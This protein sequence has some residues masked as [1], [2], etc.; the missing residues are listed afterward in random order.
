MSAFEL[1]MVVPGDARF[2]D[3]VREVAS[4]AAQ[5][6]GCRQDRAAQFGTDVEQALRGCVE[7]EPVPVTAVFRQVDDELEVTLTPSGESRLAR[8]LRISV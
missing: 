3:A 6:V 5:H 4:Q 8:T 1:R 7:D 2:C